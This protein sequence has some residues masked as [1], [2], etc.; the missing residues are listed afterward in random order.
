MTQDDVRA[1][2][3]CHIGRDIGYQKMT[4]QPNVQKSSSNIKMT[5]SIVL[6]HANGELSSEPF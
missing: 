5:S 1:N 3:Y 4:L 2:I 6:P